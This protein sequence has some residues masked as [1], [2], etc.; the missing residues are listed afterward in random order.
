MDNDLLDEA[1]EYLCEELKRYIDKEYINL[2]VRLLITPGVVCFSTKDLF[3]F[4]SSK[5]K[6]NVLITDHLCDILDLDS[7][8]VFV[9][10]EANKEFTLEDFHKIEDILKKNRK[11][12][13]FHVII[14]D[15]LRHP[16]FYV[17]Y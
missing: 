8:K 13:M 2:F 3:D 7:D 17:L 1:I 16:M 14:N 4:L 10:I 5:E 11:N 12:A 9:I 6:W 15:S